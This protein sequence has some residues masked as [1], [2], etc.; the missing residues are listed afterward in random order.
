V[1]AVSFSD[2]ASLELKIEEQLPS[3]LAQAIS[4][5]PKGGP[6]EP[7]SGSFAYT[8]LMKFRPG[9]G[10]ETSAAISGQNDFD[11]NCPSLQ[12]SQCKPGGVCNY[13][14][15]NPD[16]NA[17]NS[18]KYQYNTTSPSDYCVCGWNTTD[19]RFY[20]PSIPT[21]QKKLPFLNTRARNIY[22][23]PSADYG[24]VNFDASMACARFLDCG[25]P[26]GHSND[27][28]DQQ[29]PLC[30]LARYC[31]HDDF[32]AQI[33]SQVAG[34]NE[35]ALGTMVEQSL[36]S[37]GHL[38]CTW[39]AGGKANYCDQW[40]NIYK[41]RSPVSSGALSYFR[42]Y[43]ACVVQE[44]DHYNSDGTPVLTTRRPVGLDQLDFDSLCRVPGATTACTETW[45]VASK[46]WIPQDSSHTQALPRTLA[47]LCACRRNP[48]P[49]GIDVRSTDFI[50]AK[51]PK[52]VLSYGSNKIISIDYTGTG[53]GGSW[54]TADWQYRFGNHLFN[55][56]VTNFKALTV[57]PSVSPSPSPIPNP[58]S[59]GSELTNLLTPPTNDATS[60]YWWACGIKHTSSGSS[61]GVP[62]P[63][64]LSY[65]SQW[66]N[67]RVLLPGGSVSSRDINCGAQQYSYSRGARRV[68]GGCFET[69]HKEKDMDLMNWPFDIIGE[70]DPLYSYRFF[71][72]N[73]CG[74]GAYSDYK[75]SFTNQ[76]NYIRTLIR[77]A[78]GE[79]DKYA[80]WCPDLSTPPPPAVVPPPASVTTKTTGG[81]VTV[82]PGG[83]SSG[84]GGGFA[85]GA[86]SLPVSTSTGNLGLTILG[87]TN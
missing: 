74:Q 1:N 57:Q 7:V 77:L 10:L 67:A 36:P 66:A 65:K 5:S 76:V 87:G 35:T 44:F 56:Q 25:N 27:I 85:G 68:P 84:S 51:A 21:N 31:V 42:R 15:T 33:Y 39:T 45:D 29:N 75:K 86:S 61:L 13:L 82:T 26:T 71:C 46:A 20:D 11:P 48:T 41:D 4:E 30:P 6:F 62:D 49:D 40:Y 38:K 32:R 59:A 79:T 34:F 58:Y 18:T 53:F 73:D 9:I 50:A 22:A 19:S 23:V 70:N 60:P 81:S 3:A 24:P 83:N 78:A 54:S 28:M 2:V 8:S 63:K 14:F 69:S 52:D 16:P 72:H 80:P 47:E 55:F 17:P 37:S 43:C 12:Q 64:C